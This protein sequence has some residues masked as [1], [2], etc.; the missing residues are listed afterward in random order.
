[1]QTFFNY[2]SLMQNKNKMTETTLADKF[3]LPLQKAKNADYE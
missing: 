3:L 2:I 1:L